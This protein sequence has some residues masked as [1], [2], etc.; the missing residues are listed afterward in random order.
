MLF[1]DGIDQSKPQS[2]T[3]ARVLGGEEGFEQTIHDVF[4]NTAAF[5]LDDQVNGMLA[6]F[7]LDPHGTA[8]R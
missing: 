3:F 1:H 8:G 4:R 2:G 7:T 5:V 6:R